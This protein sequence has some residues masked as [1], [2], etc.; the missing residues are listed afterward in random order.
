[1]C[2]SFFGTYITYF[3]LQ[4]ITYRKYYVVEKI[5]VVG[6]TYMAACGLDLNLASKIKRSVSIG[7][8]SFHSKSTY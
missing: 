7:S 8:E 5:K 2:G 1:M 4:L 3:R 6:C